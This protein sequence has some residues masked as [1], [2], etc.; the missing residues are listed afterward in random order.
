MKKDAVALYLRKAIDVEMDK[1]IMTQTYA[2][3]GTC[4]YAVIL[5]DVTKAIAVTVA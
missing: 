2:V 1:D 5:H 4:H 3:V